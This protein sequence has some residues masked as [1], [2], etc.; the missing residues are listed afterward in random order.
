M[1][2]TRIALELGMGTSLRR[3]DYTRAACRAV[4][5]ALWHNSLS[6]AEAFGFEKSDMIIDIEIGVQRP[7]E[8]DVDK[9]K[10]V[11]PYGSIAVQVVEGGLDV[12]KPGTRGRT[13]IANAAIIVSFDMESASSTAQ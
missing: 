5:D 1:A 3:H 11:C 8:V 13:V 6:F 10:E 4:E 2:K 12:D 9:V 7:Q